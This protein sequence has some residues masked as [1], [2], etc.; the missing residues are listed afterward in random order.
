MSN[1]LWKVK[2]ISNAREVVKGMEVVKKMQQGDK[3]EKVEIV[4]STK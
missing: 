3:I 4:K 2:A 1:Y